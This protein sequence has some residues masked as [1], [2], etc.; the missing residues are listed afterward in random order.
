MFLVDHFV[1]DED[2][3]VDD[4]DSDIDGEPENHNESRVVFREFAV[5]RICTFAGQLGF[6]RHSDTENTECAESSCRVVDDVGVQRIVRCVMRFDQS[7]DDC[8]IRHLQLFCI[9]H[10]EDSR[11]YFVQPRRQ[12]MS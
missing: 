1:A 4:E 7:C 2:L 9:A 10:I 11:A 12:S 3:G 6:V 5:R 8:S